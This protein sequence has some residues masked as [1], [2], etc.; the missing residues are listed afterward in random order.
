VISNA[1]FAYFI[2][3]TPLDDKCCAR[4][5]GVILAGNVRIENEHRHVEFVPCLSDKDCR[6]TA[7]C[8]LPSLES[9]VRYPRDQHWASA[10]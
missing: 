8:A 6:R 1:D 3:S 7:T 9:N 5:V 4:T 2:M 10:E